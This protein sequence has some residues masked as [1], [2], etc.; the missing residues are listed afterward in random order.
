MIDF[1]NLPDT[2]TPLNRT[3]MNKLLQKTTFVETA[4]QN[5][6]DYVTEGRYYFSAEYTPT[7]IPAGINGFLEVFVGNGVIKQFWYR[8][9]T[10]NTNDWETY[11]RTYSVGSNLW[12]NWTRFATED[13]LVNDNMALR[14]RGEASTDLNNTITFGMYNLRTT[15]TNAP[16]TD[17]IYGVLLVY[18]NRGGTWDPSSAASWIT[19]EI[20]AGTT[21]YI[22]Y[23]RY[24]GWGDW[25][26]FT[27]EDL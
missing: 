23:G 11:V 16:T 22:R 17:T 27:A 2:T 24:T 7:N 10:M 9:G 5:L 3:N 18:T 19:Q 1:K 6:N 21:K 15:Y 25:K 14:Y 12:S 4:N 20:I 13:E 8:H 26:K